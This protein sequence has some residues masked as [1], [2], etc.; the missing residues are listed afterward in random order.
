MWAN[1]RA[2]MDIVINHQATK[3]GIKKKKKYHDDNMM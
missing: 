3:R 2:K 1:F